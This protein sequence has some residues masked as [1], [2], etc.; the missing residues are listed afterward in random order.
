MTP[1]AT[2]ID[3]SDPNHYLVI[4]LEATCDDKGAV[5]KREMEIIEIGAV[6]VDAAS[7]DPVDELALFIKPVCHPQLTSFCT[8]LTSIRQSDVD[9]APAFA[10]AM[11]GL[12]AW[13][14]GFGELIRAGTLRAECPQR[15]PEV[16]RLHATHFDPALRNGHARRGFAKLRKI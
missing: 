4:D 8:E 14:A 7:L 13:M 5:P 1:I 15:D 10:D 3:V 6:M 12:R 16:V 9:D 2:G 11:T